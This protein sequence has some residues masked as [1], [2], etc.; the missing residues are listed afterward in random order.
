M[1]SLSRSLVEDIGK[2]Y[3]NI[4]ESVEI[5]DEETK[6]LMEDIIST[7]SV[8]MLCEAYSVDAILDFLA[9]SSD[10][11]IVEKYLNFNENL[12]SESVVSEEHIEE[13]LAIIDESIGSAAS[14]IG[15]AM[16][17]TG[18]RRTLGV[19]AKRAMGPGARKAL[20]TAVT[21]VKDVASKAKSALPSIGKGALGLGAATLAG[22]AGAKAAGAGSNKPS[23][24]AKPSTSDGGS[25]KDLTAY[26]AG[27]GA[28]KSKQTGMSTREIEELG[29]KNI[30]RKPKE[31]SSSPSSSTPSGGSG[32][33]GGSTTSSIPS[34][35]PA[36]K[37]APKSDTKPDSGDSKLTNMQKWQKAHPKLADKVKPGQAGYD[38]I[39]AMRTKPGPNEKQDQTPTSGPAASE[40][41]K[42]EAGKD[43]EN[44]LKGEQEKMKSKQEQDKKKVESSSTKSESYDAYDILLD[45]L[46]ENGHVETLDEAHY[47]MLEMD[48]ETIQSIVETDLSEGKKKFPQEKVRRQ[49]VKHERD[50]LNRPE[51]STGKQSL[52]RAR[53]MK[54]ISSTVSAGDDP[55]K[56]MHGQDLRKLGKKE[57]R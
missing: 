16:F 6:N 1:S 2:I 8:S 41:Q 39:S 20:K 12:I 9:H 40:T 43:V 36:P 52:S 46:F 47:V 5:L 56:T 38:E 25:V 24:T 27:G 35:K 4:N 17:G 57:F 54:A 22:Y 15:R 50:Y 7:V 32:G 29:R 26:K 10:E 3:S 55:R 48:S 34:P 21:K 13:Q 23:E 33:G 28:A 31:S 37:A 18:A 30:A 53:K 19:A 49:A 11:E 14:L 45:Y 44:F 42:S 51:S